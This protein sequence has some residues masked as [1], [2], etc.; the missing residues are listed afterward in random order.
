M[1]PALRLLAALAF[2]STSGCVVVPA[3]TGGDM[4]AATRNV[5]MPQAT[6]SSA[7]YGANSRSL[8]NAQRARAGLAPVAENRRLAAAAEAHA[9]DM[10]RRRTMSHTGTG[11]T[12][13]ADR[14]RAQGY[15]YRLA[16]ENVA[17][18]YGSLPEVMA[19]WM[20]SPGHR[21]NIMASGA[22]EF[23]LGESGDYWALVL[24]RPC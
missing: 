17:W 8:L 10:A 4:T 7:S 2:L 3:A 12:T 21:R 16:A 24:A 13:V 11:G 14:I 6:L 5:P 15:C 18:G 22:A 23:G 19:G 20:Q 1:R 9:A